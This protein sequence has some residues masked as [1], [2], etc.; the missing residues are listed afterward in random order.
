MPKRPIRADDLLRIEFL[1]DP[2]IHPDGTKIL[3]SK[4]QIIKNKMVGQLFTVDLEGRSQQWTHGT[5][6]AG[7]GRW[8]PD[9][10]FIAFISGREEKKAQIYLLPT[11]GGEARRLTDLPEGSLGSFK[12]SPDGRW[13]AATFRE[14]A[15]EWT[16]AAA[17]ERKKENASTP[18]RIHE[19]AFYRLDGDGYFDQQRHQ[20][21]LINVASGETKVLYDQCPVGW[22]GFDWMP[23][24]RELVIVHT[25]N[26][27]PWAEAPND[28]FV[29]V[30]IEDGQVWKLEGLG[31]GERAEPKVSP[32]GRWIAYLGVEGAD[33]PFAVH[34]TRLYIL[35]CEGGTPR[36]LSDQ[37][38]YCLAVMGLSDTKDAYGF[39]M[40]EWTP[41]SQGLYVSVGWHGETQL[42]F[43][44]LDR[45]RVEILTSG[46]HTI[47]AGNLSRDGERLACLWGTATRLA[48][49]GVLD[50]GTSGSQLEPRVLTRWNQAFH[51]EII[52]SEPEEFW[53]ETPDGTSVHA[54]VM[55]PVGYLEPKR[56]PAVLE[57][58]GGP[59]AAYGWNFFHE[60]QLLAAEGYAV[61]FSNPRGSKGYGEAFANAIRG[62]WGDRDWEDIQ[63]VTRWMQHCP[64]IHPGQMGIM[65][66]SYGGYMT[67]WAIGHCHDWKAAIT[68]RCVSNVVSESGNSDFPWSPDAYWAGAGFGS[69]DRIEARW[70]SS[71]IS[72]FDQVQTPLLIIHSDGDLRCNVE[73]AEQVFTALQVQGV[74]SRFVRYPAS[75]SHG[76]S[77]S[78]PPDLRLHR[79]G[80]IVAWW[81]KHLKGETR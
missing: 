75:T 28:Q 49:V 61:V 33:D 11:A 29:R 43:V 42:G 51:D 48:E 37:D 55:K 60:F 16:Q 70:K 21:Y 13:I 80:E 24:S 67:N 17:E 73:Q 3:Y 40:L 57:I 12:W 18:P 41:D 54:W 64:Y 36:C 65:G 59:H 20:V 81:R 19:T 66:G 8:S 34:N 23:D 76:M 58:H 38:D 56:Y 79:L 68:D 62:A 72:T 52:L 47:T 10:Q 22:Y 32:D 6:G 25:M 78:G 15:P 31:A 35:P 9:G 45:A 69:W 7:G 39:A 4:K 2:Q 46:Q 63:A 74:E 30:Q 71:P 44:Q 26:Q 14:T 1:G 50:I 5:E 77:R 27:L 53:V